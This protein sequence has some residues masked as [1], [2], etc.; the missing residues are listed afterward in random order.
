M[1][2]QE[3][4]RT[5]LAREQLLRTLLIDPDHPEE[6]SALHGIHENGQEERPKVMAP[7]NPTQ[8]SAGKKKGFPVPMG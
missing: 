7:P 5:Q 4:G 8:R 6:G 2:Y 1:A 3:T